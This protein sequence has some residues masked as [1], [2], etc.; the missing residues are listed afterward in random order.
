MGLTAANDKLPKALL[1]PFPT[2][3]SAG[4]VPDLKGMLQAYY[5]ARGW[6][7]ATGYPT[8]EKLAMLGMDDIAADLWG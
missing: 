8:R 2:G 1:E 3:G 4:F 6:D 7:A 5:A